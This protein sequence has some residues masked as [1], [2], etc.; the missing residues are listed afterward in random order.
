MSVRRHLRHPWS[1]VGLVALGAAIA[2]C[3]GSATPNASSVGGQATRTESPSD[4]G[5]PSEAGSAGA[6]I[7]PGVVNRAAV[8]ATV[9]TFEQQRAGGDPKVAFDL[10]APRWQAVFG[11]VEQFR[12]EMSDYIG[13]GAREYRITAVTNDPSRVSRDAVRDA[14]PDIAAAAAAGRAWVVDVR[15]PGMRG[16]SAGSE[17][18][19]VAPDGTGELR[20][21][22]LH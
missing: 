15:H 19:L 5:S 7:P 8:I 21:W 13:A 18:L 2:A 11:S 14:W 6:S 20:I 16:A 4:P 10:L 3:G 22:V 1:I 12:K 17:V 9:S